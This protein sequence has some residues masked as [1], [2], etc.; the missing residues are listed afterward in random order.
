MDYRPEHADA[1]PNPDHPAQA[2]HVPAAFAGDQANRLQRRVYSGSERRRHGSGTREARLKRKLLEARMI[3]VCAIAGAVVLAMMLIRAQSE[4]ANAEAESLALASQL[5]RAE[6]ELDQAKRLVAAQDLE[7]RTLVKQRIPGASSFELDNL[8]D[9]DNSYFRKLSFSESGVGSGRRITYYAVLKN[10]GNTPVVPAAVVHLFDQNGLQM[11][12][13]RIALGAAT[14]PA[15]SAELQ[16]GETRTYS[17]PIE[18]TREVEP[19]YFLV[20]LQ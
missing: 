20:E 9:I 8:Y 4:R 1:V 15:A 10:A 13:A 3:A 11:G 17:A 12:L 6:T 19:R 5:N 16:P 18:T 7:R 14:T 2:P